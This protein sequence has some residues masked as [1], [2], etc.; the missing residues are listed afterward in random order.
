MVPTSGPCTN[1]SLVG[2]WPTP[3]KNMKV[4]WDYYSQERGKNMFQTAKQIMLFMTRQPD[5]PKRRNLLRSN[6]HNPTRTH[7]EGP[8]TTPHSLAPISAPHIQSIWD[9]RTSISINFRYLHAEER[10]NDQG[11]MQNSWIARCFSVL[12]RFLF[13]VF[14]LIDVI[15]AVC[16]FQLDALNQSLAMH[17]TVNKK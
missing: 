10:W 17:V 16:F 8:M 1:A 15:C 4:S 5:N 3:L 11:Q 9:S 7:A 2:G 12:S 13:Q 6:F 14:G